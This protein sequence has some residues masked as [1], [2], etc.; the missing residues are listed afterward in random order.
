MRSFTFHRVTVIQRDAGTVILKVDETE[1]QMNVTDAEELA[2]ALN[3]A[4]TR[5]TI[6]EQPA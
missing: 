2:V 1:H 4:A 3:S 5:A 6:A